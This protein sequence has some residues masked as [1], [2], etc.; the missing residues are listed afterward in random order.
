MR[1]ERLLVLVFALPLS[2]ACERTSPLEPALEV[3]LPI[4][5][6]VLNPAADSQLVYIT[7][8]RGTRK[9]ARVWLENAGTTRELTQRIDSAPWGGDPRPG[10]FVLPTYADGGRVQPGE[11]YRLLVSM[12]NGGE[13]EATTRVPNVAMA[14][15]LEE[16]S[17]RY[18]TDLPVTWTAVAGVS[19]YHV[20]LAQADVVFHSRVA[21][22][23]YVLR[24]DEF[25]LTSGSFTVSATP[26]F[27]TVAVQD[28][29]LTRYL[30][31]RTDPFSG[32]SVT[33]QFTGAL[34]VFGSL[35]PVMRQRLEIEFR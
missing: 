34:G 22:S 5:H 33:A 12:D 15:S 3:D 30:A 1:S 26:L 8:V 23:S 14:T 25:D 9:A 17:Y 2:V 28:E 21:E 20:T 35:V 11:V 16:R 27:L 18:N 13:I 29:H 31:M 6:A 4:V 19:R 7:S 10:P 32:T 24:A